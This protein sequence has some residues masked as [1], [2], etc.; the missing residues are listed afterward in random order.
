M[1]LA[2]RSTQKVKITKR[3]AWARDGLMAASLLNNRG[4]TWVIGRGYLRSGP[5]DRSH[6]FVGKLDP[7]DNLKISGRPFLQASAS[8]AVED[9]TIASHPAWWQGSPTV[10]YSRVHRVQG[11]TVSDIWISRLEDSNVRKP[12]IVAQDLSWFSSR[13]SMVKEP[14]VLGNKLFYEFCDGSTSR[15]AAADIK[16]PGEL[17]NHKLFLDVRPGYW[18][19]EH[20]S[21]GPILPVVGSRRALMLYNGRSQNTWSIGIVVFNTR[22][23]EILERS[24]KPL[25]RPGRRVGPGGQRI[26]FSSAA[27]PTQNGWDLY[28]HEA[29]QEIKVARL[30]P[31]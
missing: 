3:P 25:L 15:I 16:G 17:S 8:L 6:L 29:D 23:L 20:V 13:V 7:M 10:L 2:V 5:V 4:E 12:L 14:E 24:I 30:S 1:N 31:N 26:A 11:E 21:A 28:Y 9:P 27:R 18:D 19:S 22:T